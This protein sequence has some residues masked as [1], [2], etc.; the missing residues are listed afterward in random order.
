MKTTLIA[1]MDKLPSATSYAAV[2]TQRQHVQVPASA[3]RRPP[4]SGEP[5][6]NISKESNPPGPAINPI[7]DV[8]PPQPQRVCQL[9]MRANQE[10]PV[11]ISARAPIVAEIPDLSV[12]NNTGETVRKQSVLLIGDSI[13]KGVNTRG[14]QQGVQKQ[15]YRRRNSTHAN[16]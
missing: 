4:V 1:C 12:N 10:I 8:P 5:M 6:I 2:V 11:V 7:S 15:C 9:G 13:L 14:L 16:R 3:Q